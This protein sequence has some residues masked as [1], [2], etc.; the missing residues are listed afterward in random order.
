MSEPL[1]PRFLLEGAV[2]AL[3]QCGL[4]LSDASVLYANKSYATSVALA[5]FAR[6]ELGKWKILLE[7]RKKVVSGQCVTLTEMQARCTDH[8]TKQQY[9]MLST[10]MRGHTDSGLG[11]LLSRRRQ[12]APDSA[13]WKAATE[14]I[15]KLERQIAKR[16]PADRH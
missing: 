14:Q 8:E 15:A 4:L 11:Q 7:L 13:E 12:C 5:G 9:G 3:E 6:E 16:T 10:V 1:T 2:Y